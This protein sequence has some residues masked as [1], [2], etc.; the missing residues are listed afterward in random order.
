MKYGHIDSGLQ[1]GF[2][3]GTQSSIICQMYRFK[4]DDSTMFSV[5]MVTVCILKVCCFP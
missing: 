2:N 1:F 5:N 4:V 3:A